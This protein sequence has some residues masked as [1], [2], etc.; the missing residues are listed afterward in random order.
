MG[1][2]D[3]FRGTTSAVPVL[4]GGKQGSCPGPYATGSL[5]KLNYMLQPGWQHLGLRLLKGT[6]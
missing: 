6:Q 5:E 3:R 4:E 2:Q 1:S